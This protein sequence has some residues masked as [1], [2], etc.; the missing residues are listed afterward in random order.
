V[1][2]LNGFC[3]ERFFLKKCIIGFVYADERDAKTFYKKFKT[4]KE[5][6]GKFL[7]VLDFYYF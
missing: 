4:S 5:D 7:L 1:D 3:T 6:K 2:Y